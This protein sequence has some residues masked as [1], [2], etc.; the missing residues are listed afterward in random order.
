MVIQSTYL[1]QLDIT[2]FISKEAQK[3]IDGTVNSHKTFLMMIVGLGHIF[4]YYWR[5]QIARD[6]L[7]QTKSLLTKLL[8]TAVVLN[9]QGFGE[10]VSGVRR[11]EILSN[12]SK[13]YKIYGTHFIFPTTKGSM[14]ACIKL[15]AFSTS[16]KVKNHCFRTTLCKTNLKTRIVEK[17]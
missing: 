11:Q 8:P 6:A 4:P 10:S 2:G 3:R 16:N 5:R 7:C 13:K 9:L 14:N 1:D 15:V 17:F 12:N